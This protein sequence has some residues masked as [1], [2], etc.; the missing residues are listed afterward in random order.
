MKSFTLL[1]RTRRTDADASLDA[2][3]DPN[4]AVVDPTADDSTAVDDEATDLRWTG[5]GSTALIT[6]SMVIGLWAALIVV[7]TGTA[8]VVASGS[9]ST[10]APAPAA[11]PLV[12]V[13]EQ[14]AVSG[15]AEGFVATWLTT[16]VGEEEQ[17]SSYIASASTVTLPERP[18]EVSGVSTAGLSAGGDHQWSVTVAATVSAPAGAPA[19]TRRYFQVA[20]VYDAG[21]MAAQALPS[22]VAAPTSATAPELAYR[23]RV[24]PGQPLT[25]AAQEFL[26][27]L[28]TGRGDV[29]RYTSPG[30][31]ITAVTPTPYSDLEVDDVQVDVDL[32]EETDTPA[33][34]DQLHLLVTATALA[35]SGK[36]GQVVSELTVQYPL[37]MTARDGRWEV[38]SIDQTPT[39]ADPADP[40]SPSATPTQ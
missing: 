10:V 4:S 34:G 25:T 28:L 29:A 17:L 5:T 1:K 11:A 8:V 6:R 21:A 22:P 27:A 20:V 15:F 2:D 39:P 14:S 32:G 12:D 35:A 26:D 18:W 33:N 23:Y 13:D 16:A 40:T 38:T 36:D 30:A 7:P 9:S 19:P 31:V 3:N 37:T 24:S